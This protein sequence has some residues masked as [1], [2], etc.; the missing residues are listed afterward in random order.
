MRP[1]TKLTVKVEA[2]LDEVARMRFN[3][4]SYRELEIETGLSQNYLREL[5]SEKIQ[6]L[7]NQSRETP[8]A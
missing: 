7:T 1:R 8:G 6:A 5:I 2:R 4:P 3:T